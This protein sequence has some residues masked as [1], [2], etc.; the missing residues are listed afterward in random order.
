[1]NIGIIGCGN[2][3]QTL[4][5][6]IVAKGYISP[7]N[8]FVNDKDR[9]K[10]KN[11]KSRLK[12]N[13][14][15]SNSE[16]IESSDVIILATKPQDVVG[17][18]QDVALPL[19]GK[20]LISICA[21]IKTGTLEKLL[22]K[23]PV[24]RVMPNMP[25]VISQGISAISLG[26]Y[27]TGNNGKISRSI[28]SCIGDVV[29]LDEQ[30]M[31][32]VTAISGSGPAYFFYLAERLIEVAKEMGISN[33]AAQKLVLKTVL[34]SAMLMNQRKLSPQIL[35]KRVSSKGGTTE[36]AFA[37]L[38]RQ[39]LDKILTLAL[40]AAAQ[41]SKKLEKKLAKYLFQKKGKN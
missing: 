24:V 26:K 9:R 30:L 23:I 8:I 38:R 17:V 41:R 20:L 33:L 2:M 36:A 35:R 27:V 10:L 31:D 19:K 32:A 22:G 3:G 12:I 11:V 1:M 6:G 16:L 5:S 14:S 39:G 18:F 37:V 4:I 7:R 40:K 34:G 29:E 28:F 21:G 25:A 13:I 15:R